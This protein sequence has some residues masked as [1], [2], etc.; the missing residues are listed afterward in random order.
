MTI[1]Y[2]LVFPWRPS[3]NFDRN[4]A[5]ELL[6]YGTGIL[7][8]NILA[9][10]LRDTDSILVGRYLGAEALGIYSLAYRVPDILVISFCRVISRVTFPV[11]VKMRD[12]PGGLT[13]GFLKAQKYI[14][15][16]TI[17]AG[18]GLALVA[19][20]FVLTFFTE[21]WIEAIPVFQAISIYAMLFSFS[22]NAGS[23]YKAQG[24]PFVLT[25][26]ALMRFALL[27]PALYFTVTKIGTLASIGWVHACVALVAGTI[28]LIVAGRMMD[29]TLWRMLLELRPVIVAGLS[30]LVG[31]WGV[32]FMCRSC[33]PL[34]QLTL[35]VASGAIVFLP[36]LGLQ[37]REE[38]AQVLGFVKT[39][40]RRD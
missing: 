10:F 16:F 23:V 28:N 2:W 14:T 34:L 27:L 5:R 25:K 13:E 40:L 39:T 7:S 33:A 6:T 36:V 29:V 37:Q 31:V 20:P 26:L 21:K 15:Y 18:V 3:F 22:Y 17:P 32:L 35:G 19:R 24:Q 4:I 1:A 9:F 38:A 11:Y 8:V 30:M 12:I